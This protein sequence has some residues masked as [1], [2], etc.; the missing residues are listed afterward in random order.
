MF[1]KPSNPKVYLDNC[2]YNRPYDDQNQLR[3]E[4]ET[5]AKLSIQ[6]QITNGELDLVISFMSELENDD[7]P[8]EERRQS[9]A[10]FFSYSSTNVQSNDELKTLASEIVSN[11][12]KPEDA[13]HVASAI[14]AKCDYLFTT[15]D[16]ILKYKDDRIRIMNPTDFII[17]G[18]GDTNE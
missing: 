13:T 18:A 15:D 16:R 12:L 6:E 1:E 5:K 8:F 10:G 7:N 4:I 9:I 2:C 11:G 17:E 3:V 14:F